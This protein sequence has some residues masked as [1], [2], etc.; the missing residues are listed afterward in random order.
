MSLIET[1]GQLV[2]NL[3]TGNHSLA[4][5]INYVYVIAVISTFVLLFTFVPAMIVV[6]GK[7]RYVYFTLIVFWIVISYSTCSK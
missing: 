5:Q 6:P 2:Q 4:V 7:H 1:A 3:T